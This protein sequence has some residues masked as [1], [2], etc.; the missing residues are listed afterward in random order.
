MPKM[1]PGYR[2][3]VRKKIVAEALALFT[4]KG[5]SATTMGEIAAR[6]GVT[7]AAIYQYYPSKLDLFSAVAE[8]QRQRLAGILERSFGGS[9][10]AEGAAVLFDNLLRFIDS[11]REI[12]SDMIAVAHRDGGLRK[13]MEEDL[14]GDLSI[15]ETF[16]ERRKARGLI[17]SSI[18]P[19]ILAMACHALINGLMFDVM[20]GM[21]PAE[22]KKVWLDAVDDLLR[23]HE[24]K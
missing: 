9:D 24:R 5:Y 6:L 4:E 16:I 2:D 12:Y 11:S 3:E 23:V 17:H 20:M 1:Y 19:K 7:K 22:A 15:I 14:K 21:D 10:V 8:Y 18:D 13:I